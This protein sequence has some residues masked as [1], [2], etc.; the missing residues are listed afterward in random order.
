MSKTKEPR[1][2]FVRDP[3]KTLVG[4][5]TYEEAKRKAETIAET[6]TQRVRVRLRSR[7][8]KWDV[9]VKTR[10]EDKSDSQPAP[11]GGD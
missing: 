4:I 7:T 8:G 5:E 6:E 11:T 1:Y 10:R 3:E 2:V 9:V